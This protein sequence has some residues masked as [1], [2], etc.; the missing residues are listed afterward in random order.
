MQIN[1][2]QPS[3]RAAN[4]DKYALKMISDRVPAGQFDTIVNSFK[5][6]Y[7]D[8]EFDILIG[9]LPGKLKRLDAMISYNCNGIKEDKGRFFQHI[10]EGIF[11]RFFSSPKKFLERVSA[12]YDKEAVPFAKNGYKNFE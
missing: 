2:N 11:K 6:K 1:N 12:I 4:F 8:S 9:M 3:F 7:K 10:E 5:D